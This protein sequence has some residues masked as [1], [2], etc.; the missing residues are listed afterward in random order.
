M[1]IFVCSPLRGY[2]GEPSEANRGI[3]RRLM[4]AVFDAGHSPF[5]PHL[6]YPQVLSE[7]PDD[8]EKAFKANFA[9]LCCCDELWVFARKFEECS[10]GMKLEIDGGGIRW[11]P[12]VVYMPKVFEPIAQELGR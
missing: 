3:A 1:K 4:K 7:S 6:L 8:L 5:V 9:F 12:K 11:R 2:D 10:R